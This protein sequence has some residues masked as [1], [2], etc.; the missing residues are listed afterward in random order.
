MDRADRLTENL[1]AANI[2][3]TAAEVTALDAALDRIP[4]S[5][6]YGGAPVIQK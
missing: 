4:M 3:L 5:A 1:G 6:V 2:E